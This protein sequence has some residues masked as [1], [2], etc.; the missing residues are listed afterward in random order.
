MG[1][2]LLW[3][4]VALLQLAQFVQ[5]VWSQLVQFACTL[6]YLIVLLFC[7]PVYLS[8]R[9]IMGISVRNLPTRNLLW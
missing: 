5:S 8:E 4:Q 2:R 6:L 3:F 1:F 9:V 7:P